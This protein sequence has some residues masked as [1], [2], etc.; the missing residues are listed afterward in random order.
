MN[1]NYLIK[2]VLTKRTQP[3]EFNLTKTNLVS[4]PQKVKVKVFET[5]PNGFE[6]KLWRHAPKIKTPQPQTIEGKCDRG[7]ERER[8]RERERVGESERG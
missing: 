8:E 6:R 1:F 5:C 4:F 7:R 2:I 3:D